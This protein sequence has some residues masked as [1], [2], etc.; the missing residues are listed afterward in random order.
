MRFTYDG[1]NRLTSKTV[2]NWNKT[3]SYTY[4]ANGNRK[5]MTDPDGGLTTYE[6]DANDRLI[7]LTNPD[8]LQTL[9]NYDLAGRLLRQDNSNGTYTIYTYDTADRVLSIEHHKS[10]GDIFSSF[11]YTYDNNGNRLTMTDQDGGVNR[12]TYDGDN[13]LTKV[14]Y[15]NGDVEEYTFDGKGN[16]LSLKK[17]DEL[18]EYTYDAADRIQSAGNTTYK[19]DGNGNMIERNEDG[20]VT[21]Y[22]YD[23]ENH[24]IKILLPNQEEVSFQYDPLG[25]RIK[26]NKFYNW[27]NPIFSRR[28]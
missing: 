26:K 14:E 16:R 23:G 27:N 25:D 5:T 13:R 17:N 6:Y 9:F 11:A 20:E 12:Y 28:G 24:L 7:S 1:L 8:K 22:F 15:A 18:I 2:E 10:N 3:I 19:F 21:N 4:D